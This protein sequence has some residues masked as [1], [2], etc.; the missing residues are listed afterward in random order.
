[1]LNRTTAPAFTRTTDFELILPEELVLQ[2][3]ARIFF[4]SGGTQSVIRVE[5]LIKAGRWL[6]RVWGASYFSAQLLSKGTSS[7]KSFAIAQLFDQYGAHLEISPGLDVV[8][9]SLYTLTKNLQPTLAMFRELLQDSAFPEKELSQ[10][11]SIYL[12]NLRVNQ[13]KTSFQASKLFRKKLFGENHPYGKELEA[14][15]VQTLTRE[16]LIDHYTSFG[17]DFIV[18]VSGKIDSASR[19]NIID[20][21]SSLSFIASPEK[22]IT[23]PNVNALHERVSKEG[24]VQSSIRM[25]KKAIARSH[26]DY[27]AVLFL[28]HIFGGYFGS[29]LMKNIREEKGLSYGIYSS[30]HTLQHDSYV[31]IG[32][33]VNNENLD[34]AFEEIRKELKRLRTE[35]VDAEELEIARNHFIGSLQAEITTPFAHADKIK[36]M[37]MFRL[38]K[39]YYQNLI[40]NIDSVQA[41]QLLDIASRYFQ[42]G[43]FI[44]VS[45]G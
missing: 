3:G 32:A 11:K 2:N 42:E 36:N 20:E 43:D 37:H 27:A 15:E 14:E 9:V 29:R 25:G 41:D 24:S 6:E 45:V 39:N 10:L 4:I 17:K 21:F 38:P 18:I 7:K 8:S 19:Q 22:N 16:Q 31:V 44:E 13:E 5:V 1:M 26:P 28:N 33:D 35:P 23:A 30:I 40:H 34:I 12:Q